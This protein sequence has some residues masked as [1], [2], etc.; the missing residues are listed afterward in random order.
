MVGIG[1]PQEPV[2]V[3]RPRISIAGMVHGSVQ[4]AEYIRFQWMVHHPDSLPLPPGGLPRKGGGYGHLMWG[5]VIQVCKENPAGQSMSLEAPR[6]GEATWA[7]VGV[8]TPGKL[9]VP[10]DLSEV[11]TLLLE[12]DIVERIGLKRP[13]GKAE[14]TI[15]LKRPHCEDRSEPVAVEPFVGVLWDVSQP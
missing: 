15:W 8:V 9:R 2:N 7:E 14:V 1:R 10:G 12:P 13:D 6:F 11:W 3:P 5:H 4:V